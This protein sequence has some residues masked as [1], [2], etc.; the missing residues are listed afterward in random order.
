MWLRRRS[1]LSL[2]SFATRHTDEDMRNGRGSAKEFADVLAAFGNDVVIFSDK[3]VR[4]QDNK[5]LDVAWK[6]WYK[7]AV[8]ELVRQLHGAM[9]WVKRFPERVFLDSK[10]QGRLPVVFSNTL[11]V[12]DVQL[13]SAPHSRSADGGCLYSCGVRLVF[14]ASKNK[15]HLSFSGRCDR[16]DALCRPSA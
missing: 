16:N 14:R 12:R 13:W 9:N 7:R 11:L 5:P 4:F 8:Q 1:F 3:H 10:F 2:W 15:V 6:R